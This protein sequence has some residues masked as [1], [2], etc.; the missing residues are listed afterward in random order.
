MKT[1]RV[2]TATIKGLSVN[3]TDTRKHFFIQYEES[4]TLIERN[5][6][7]KNYQDYVNLNPKQIKLYRIAMYG[8]EALSDKEREILSFREKLNIKHKHSN[9]QKFINRWKQQ[10]THKKINSLLASLFPNSKMVA[11]M[12]E[13]DNYYDDTLINYATFKELHVNNRHII[14]KLIECECLPQNFYTLK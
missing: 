3:Y 6:T 13:D 11:D 7:F 10:L 8:V 5:K 14:N 9:T 4:P 1:N 2:V 12:C